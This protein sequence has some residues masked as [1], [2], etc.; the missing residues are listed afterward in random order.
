MSQATI[1]APQ[2]AP[3]DHDD[4]DHGCGGCRSPQSNVDFLPD[5]LSQAPLPWGGRLLELAWNEGL[6]NC[7]DEMRAEPRSILMVGGCRQRVLA[8][9]LAFLF[10]ATKI[11][12]VDPDPEQVR[13]AEADIHCRFSFIPSDLAHLPF[14]DNRFDLT[15]VPNLFEFLPAKPEAWEEALVHLARVTDG[16]LF[17]SLQQQGVWW[18][19][20]GSRWPNFQAALSRH[21]LTLPEAQLPQT[22]VIQ[23]ARRYGEVCYR[24]NPYPWSMWMLKLR[25]IRET[26]LVL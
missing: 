4:H 17:F 3:H 12:L 2:S 5:E 10:P 1:S 13:R 16:H 7:L 15:L 6:M 18:Q 24:V 19:L 25:P 23:A 14:E 22:Q 21:G 26:R 11:T 9:K 20:L 8:R